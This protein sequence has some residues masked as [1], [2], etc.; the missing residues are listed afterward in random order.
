MRPG[1]GVTSPWWTPAGGSR[2]PP[3]QT[4][5]PAG[6]RPPKAPPRVPAQAGQ[7]AGGPRRV[8]LIGRPNVGKSSLLNKLAGQHRALVDPVAGTT[9]D[10]VDEI[11][12]LGGVP[13]RFGDTP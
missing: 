8:A 10:P 6:D 1:V 7:T 13:W 9:R 12:E 5:P 4:A 11:I 2:S 3:P